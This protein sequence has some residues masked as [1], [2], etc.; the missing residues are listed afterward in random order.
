M[1]QFLTLILI[2]D[3][4]NITEFLTTVVTNVRSC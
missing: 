4:Y 1:V 2:S 3:S